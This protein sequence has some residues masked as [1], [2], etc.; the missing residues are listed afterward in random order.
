MA[1]I[2]NDT[3]KMDQVLIVNF[4][5]YL[6]RKAK[7]DE[8]I[9]LLVGAIIIDDSGN[10]LLMKRNSSDFMGGIFEIP[11]GKIELNETIPYALSREIKEETNLNLRKINSFINEFDYQSSSGKKSRQLNFTVSI[12]CYS[13]PIIL[14]EHEDY[15][16]IHY[17]DIEKLTDITP[18]LKYTL[19]IVA[20]ALSQKFE[21]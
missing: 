1:Y 2:E 14:S 5:D 8:V 9:N 7:V 15:K 13:V 12:E 18:E 20:F 11:S 3:N 21:D 19:L 16:W 17:S 4:Y 6:A 10:F